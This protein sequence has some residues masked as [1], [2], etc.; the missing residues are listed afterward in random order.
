MKWNLQSCPTTVF[1][2]RLRHFRGSKHTLNPPAY[3]QG[4]RPPRSTPL[5][6]AVQSARQLRTAQLQAFL[7]TDFSLTRNHFIFVQWSQVLDRFLSELQSK[8]VICCSANP[9]GA[10]IKSN[11]CYR[12][13]SPTD[14]HSKL[15]HKPMHEF[16]RCSFRR[17]SRQRARWAWL[18]WTHVQLAVSWLPISAMTADRH[19]LGLDVDGHLSLSLMTSSSSTPHRAL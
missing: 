4:S 14:R 6:R 10:W 18:R 2:E 13:Q 9:F 3:F 1:N 17:T 11:L 16:G 12:S 7:L 8:L 5:I 19:S 15:R